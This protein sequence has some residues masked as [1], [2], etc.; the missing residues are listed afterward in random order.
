MLAVAA[1]RLPDAD[2]RVAKLAAPLPEGDFDLVVSALTV[3]HLDASGKADLFARVFGR[4]RP[5]GR[6]VLTDVIVPED[7]NDV[8]IPV[9]GVHDKPSS[10]A[11]QI[12]WAEEAGFNARLDWSF[13]DFAVIVADRP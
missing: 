4:L 12:A 2:L 3:H 7:P 11:E 1:E 6:F 10:I 9:D 5:G 13:A 8:T